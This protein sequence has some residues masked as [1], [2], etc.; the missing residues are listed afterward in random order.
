MPGFELPEN[1]EPQVVESE[2]MNREDYD[3]ILEAGWLDFLEKFF[4]DLVDMPDKVEAVMDAMAS[5]MAK[6]A[7]LHHE[8]CARVN[9]CIWYAG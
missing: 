2:L 1:D 9:V 7:C 3:R 6:W 8:R 5:Y 4:Y